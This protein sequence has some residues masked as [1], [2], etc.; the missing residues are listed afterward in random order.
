MC[1]TGILIHFAEEVLAV[2]ELEPS[3][4]KGREL[5]PKRTKTILLSFRDETDYVGLRHPSQI[6]KALFN[7]A[8]GSRPWHHEF[9][10]HEIGESAVIEIRN[11]LIG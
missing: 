11:E 3:T 7:P 2:D 6:R 10:L 1:D 8:L 4:P 9:I 5:E